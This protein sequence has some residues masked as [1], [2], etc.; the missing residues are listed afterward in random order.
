MVVITIRTSITT[1]T[2]TIICLFCLFRILFLFFISP[3]LSLSSPQCQRQENK[4]RRR[5]PN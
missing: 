3:S 5:T 4:Q 2:I 1:I